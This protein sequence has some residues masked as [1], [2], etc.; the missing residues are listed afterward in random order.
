VLLK[1]VGGNRNEWTQ[2]ALH[3]QSENSTGIGVSVEMF[4]G[5]LR[6]TW[7]IPGASGY[8]SQGPAVISAGLGGEAQA[9]AVRV[10]WTHGPVQVTI[11]VPGEQKTVISQKDTAATP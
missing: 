11:P 9:N 4:A 5:A 8:M 3:G 2:F 7:E 6:Q 1:A 10:R